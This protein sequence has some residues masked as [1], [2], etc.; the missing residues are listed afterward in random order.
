MQK[1][2]I[3]NN[4]K[5]LSLIVL[6]L[7][8]FSVITPTAQ[9]FFYQ[10]HIKWTLQGFEDVDSPITEMCRP[11]LKEFVDGNLAQDVPVLH[12]FDNKVQSYIGT[13]SRGAGLQSC[14]ELADNTAE[15]CYCYGGGMHWIAQD[16]YSH[17]EEGIT[18]Q[19]LEKFFALNFVGHMVV[20]RNYEKKSMKLYESKNDPILGQVE[21]YNS[22]ALG[23]LFDVGA[24]GELIPNDYLNILSKQAGIDITNDA[25]I[26]RSGYL[27][28]GFYSTVYRDKVALPWWFWAI[29]IVLIIIGLIIGILAFY[30]GISGWKWIFLLEGILILSLGALILFS[31]FTGTTWKITTILIEIPPKLGYLSVSDADIVKFDALVQQATNNYLMTGEAVIDDGSGL[32]YVDRTGKQVTGALTKAESRSLY[33]L[34]PIIA[35]LFLFMNYYIIQ[36]MLKRKVNKV[37]SIGG[38]ILVGL[39][40]GIFGLFTI[41]GIFSLFL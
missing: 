27:G 14:L 39:F 21:V 23:T 36:K 9:A 17:L 15:K 22:D 24:D 1:Q 35:L 32:S 28:E 5:F 41:A 26:F 10:N 40:L 8:L 30:F 33:I 29:S 13:H 6:S 2:I 12:Y 34:M 19:Y 16:R 18:T 31:I 3:K 38:N 25:K 11:Y 4:K 20:E 37:F 7:M